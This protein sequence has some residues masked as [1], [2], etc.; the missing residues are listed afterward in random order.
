MSFGLQRGTWAADAVIS[1]DGLYRYSLT[2]RWDAGA[3]G[4]RNA[5]FIMLN[6]S[7]ADG[8]QDDPTIRRCIGFAK[9]EGCGS[10]TVVN[11]FA[12][13][14]TDPRALLNADNPCGPDNAL[15][16]E[17]ALAGASIAVAAWGSFMWENRKRLRP[18]PS[19]Q[20]DVLW[21]L[22][23]T[24]NGEPRHPLY[25]RGDQPLVRWSW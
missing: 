17:Q 12:Y 2:R 5:T 18:L 22:G 25:V 20:S 10:L 1:D 19:F 7:T 6:P 13:R 8:M 15:H 23:T 11:L 3:D 24:K 4:S 9:R 21:C 14:A 16:I